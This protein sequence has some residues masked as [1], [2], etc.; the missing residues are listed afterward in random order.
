MTQEIWKKL[1]WIATF[2]LKRLL[3]KKSLART[4]FLAKKQ[5][6]PPKAGLQILLEK[7]GEISGTRFAR[8]TL[9]VLL[10][11]FLQNWSETWIFTAPYFLAQPSFRIFGKRIH[12]IFALPK[13]HIEHKL[14]LRSA[15]APKCGKLQARKFFCVEEINNAS[16]INTISCETIRHSMLNFVGRTFFSVVHGILLFNFVL[17]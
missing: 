5:S 15:I 2:L 17:D 1:H 12:I 9:W 13:R 7:W 11:L 10:Y 14:S 4:S 16:T 6:V 3:P 8:P